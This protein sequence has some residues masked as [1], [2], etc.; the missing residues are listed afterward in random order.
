MKASWRKVRDRVVLVLFVA[1]AIGA[2][3]GTVWLF[4]Q[5][6][7]VDRLTRGVGD[8]WFLS[9]DD[10]RWFRMDESRR[11]V[12][13][14]AMPA[15]LRQAFIAIE[16][17]RFYRHPGVDPLALGRAVVRNLRAPGTVEG[18]STI[19]QQLARTLFLSNRKTYGRKL[20]EAV[21]AL[22]IEARLSKDQ[23][24]ELYL[25]RIY[26]G[27]GVY[28]VETMA[29]YLFGKP[30][31]ELALA[32]SALI[33]GLARAPAAL[34]P[35]S[36]LD[37]AVARSHLVLARMRQERLITAADEEAARKA[38]IRIRPHP[39]ARDARAGYAKEYLRQR[40][41]DHFGTDHPPD[42]HVKT[43]FVQEL[44]AIA[45]Q[46]V[47][48]GLARYRRPELQAALVALDP[49]TG[50]ILAL[51]GGRDFRASQFNR[52]TR[53]RRQPGSAFKPLLYAAA[54][55]HGFSPVSVL[56]G[57]A[58]TAGDA[59]VEWTPRNASGAT[60]EAMTLR[61]AIVESNNR[62]A[63]S[64]QGRVGSAPVLE[65]A[66]HAGLTGL[67]DVPS[68]AL[69][70]GVVTPLQM[71]AAFAMF[72]NGGLAVRPRAIVSVT[73]AE[74]AQVLQHP[75]AAERAISPETAYQMVSLLSDAVDRGTGMGAR[76][77]GVRGPVGGKTGT[78]NDFKDAWFVG[79]SSSLVVGVW[80]GYDQPRTIAQDAYGAKY[81]LPIWSDFMRQAA[82]Y[83]P[84]REFARPA[85][86]RGVQ[87][88]R[89]SYGRAVEGCQVYTEY[90]KA[91][92]QVPGLCPLHR[93]SGTQQVRRSIEGFFGGLGRRIGRIF[94][95][96]P[97]EADR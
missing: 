25:N 70:A 29:S 20:R 60:P 56:D 97:S 93:G 55:E 10:Q 96:S 15:H 8:T 72:P 85:T 26:L 35:W 9:A 38:R 90:L 54:L 45:E 47:A 2:T 27:S 41:R 87:L 3:A 6:R 5:A 33:A 21:L 59:P 73:D 34:S 19:S 44:Q 95:G 80:V 43:T 32:E 79:F 12:P 77:A 84:P 36:N 64:L 14:S 40:F 42:W 1:L 51:V 62:A 22:M 81:A 65:L 88:C 57:L 50:D 61:A 52:A 67:P 63:T 66:S 74:G 23:V 78:T 89:V 46:S 76:Q 58:T 18:G 17:H 94:R 37:G 86:L 75:V 82:R 91:G 16:D 7:A 48:D 92:D 13:L 69:G 68:L 30:A 71:T 28:G 31:S 39:G 53:S 11:D 24:L 4:R 49:A 83:R